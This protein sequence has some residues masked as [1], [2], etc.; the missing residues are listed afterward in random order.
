MN[1]E[2]YTNEHGKECWRNVT[3]G[4]PMDALEFHKCEDRDDEDRQ[5]ALFTNIG[6]ITVVDRMTGFGWRDVETGYRDMEKKFWLASGGCDARNCGAQ[7]IG[8]VI[9]FVKDNANTCVGI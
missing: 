9:Q 1:P 4:T 2:R 6:D 3:T 5:W 7:T 8:E